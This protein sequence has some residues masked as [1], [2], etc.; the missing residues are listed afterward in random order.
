MNRNITRMLCAVMAMLLLV[1]CKPKPA[2]DDTAPKTE[3]PSAT[4]PVVDALAPEET[5]YRDDFY[6]AVNSEWLATAVIP[7]TQPYIAVATEMSDDIED[8]LMADFADMMAGEREDLSPEM[9]NFLDYY[10][11]TSDF[12]A[13]ETAGAAPLQPY[14]SRIDAIA[15]VSDLQEM[16]PGWILDGMPSP[17]NFGVTADMGDA[18]VNA[19]YAAGESILFYDTVYYEDERLLGMLQQLFSESAMALLAMAGYDEAAA[20]D[21]V[22]GTLAFDSAIAAYAS[23]AEEQADVT[24]RYNPIPSAEFAG[25]SENLDL[26]AIVTALTGEL[27]DTVVVTEPEYFAALDTVVSGETLPQLKSW[28][29]L[30]TV[31]LIAPYLTDDF[32]VEAGSFDRVMMGIGEPE[33]RES[34]AYNAAHGIFGEVAGKYYGEAYFGAEAKQDVTDMVEAM[35][36]VYRQRLRENTWLSDETKAKATAKLDAMIVNVGYPDSLDPLYS[37]MIPDESRSLP[38]NMTG[39]IHMI[40]EQMFAALGEA[41]DK[42]EWITTADTVNAF[43]D[44]TGNSINFPAA[45]LQA[46]FYSLEQSDSANYGG[47]GTVI[48][49]EM[50]HAFDTN[51]AL[52]DENGSMS[53]W[54]TEAD[55]A[56]FET[57]AAAVVERYDGV[58]YAGGAV[59]GE[60]TVSE[61]IA[62]MGG[63]TCALEALGNAD[64]EE[65]FISYATC[66]REKVSEEYAQLALT[67]D[68]HAPAKLRTNLPLQDVDEFYD[69]FGVQEGD[70]MYLAPELRISIW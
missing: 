23:S 64:A 35:V 63:L 57:L 55:Y 4:P 34:A 13:R 49:H 43:Y 39:F 36:E 38:E 12:E 9:R 44:V 19:L 53:N 50:S 18:T 5:G 68:P 65:F 48:G 37:L 67:M 52:F 26:G 14:L 56:T 62:D 66:W 58:P 2:A 31:L 59:N 27:P 11:M 21:I 25:Y 30:K 47:I 60:L 46:P 28:M 45:I 54:W 15:S 51:G 69:A 20:A 41:A 61:N 1:S 17:V 32:R 8:I 7:V 3:Q 70:G 33:D 24:G 16:L 40:T 29:T 22:T 10:S 6:D 42:S